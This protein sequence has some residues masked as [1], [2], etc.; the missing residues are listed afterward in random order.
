M[1]GKSPAH[2]LR[3]SPGQ[4]GAIINSPDGYRKELRALPAGVELAEKLAG[5][6]DWIQLFVRNKTDLDRLAP[7]AIQALKPE[8]LL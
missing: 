1:P 5:K 2:K 7:R 4:M 8:S 6:I 3:L